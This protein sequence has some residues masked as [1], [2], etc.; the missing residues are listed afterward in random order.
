MMARCTKENGGRMQRLVI[1]MLL[2]GVLV[3][4][5]SA[6]SW[7]GY[8]AT[9]NSSWQISR[10]S[11]N[12]TS[13]I[14]GYVEGIVSPVEYRGRTISPYAHY[15]KDVSINDVKVKERTAAR[16]GRYKAEELLKMQSNLS[17]NPGYTIDKSAG[18]SKWIIE[19]YQDW[20]L[21]INSS[22]SIDY[23]GQNINEMEYI[24]NGPDSISSSYLYNIKLTNERNLDLSTSNLNATVFATN[25]N[26]LS[27]SV[28]EDIKIN[29]EL[30][31]HSTGI[32]DLKFK[33]SGGDY[34][35]K[36]GEYNPQ[37]MGEERYVGDYNIT[38]RLQIRENHTRKRLPDSWLPCCYQGW[39]DLN[40]MDKKGH[41]AEAVFDCNCFKSDIN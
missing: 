29:Y 2:I 20:P 19:F 24:S 33:Q 12:L 35:M 4:C 1:T 23:I 28:D 14:S 36:T 30:N 11:S 41:S 6:E 34:L 27:V 18:T 10:Q 26:I 40:S 21:S 13:D 38:R 3:C 17:S 39:K 25:E 9:N 37:L 32:A 8:V 5:V 7:S 16:Q 31:S 15:S 22:R